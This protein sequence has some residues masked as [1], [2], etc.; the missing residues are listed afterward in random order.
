[1]MRACLEALTEELRRLKAG[2][3][4]EVS[5]SEESLAVLRRVVQARAPER[6][7]VRTEG[8]E[9]TAAKAGDSRKAPSVR[10][11][12]EPVKPEPGFPPPPV[13]A[14][15]EGDKAMQWAWLKQR[16]LN[17]EVCRAQVRP[18]KQLVLGEGDLDAAIL[19]VGEP[20]GAEEEAIGESFVGSAGQLLTKMIGAMGLKR[21]AVYISNIMNW[22]PRVP[23]PEGVEQVGERTPTAEELAYCLPH[24]RA[25]LAI[26]KP[27]VVVALGV[28][29]ARG[30]LG[31]EA[32]KAL[33][34][35]RGEWKEFE[36]TPVMVTYHPSYF[37]RNNSNQSKRLI[38]EDL[39]KVMER[40]DI[41]ISDRQRGFFCSAERK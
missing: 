3:V 29:A 4:K 21:E 30:L 19:F 39:L 10:V 1:M 7:A 26:V 13:V 35:V 40:V 2:G 22:R 14:L 41:P 33:P 15:P 8:A 36:G 24:L 27:K 25:Q 6:V 32:F 28:T 23:T 18:G 31:G 38:W 5:V 9:G 37:L 34:D 16:V 12:E 17:D 20:P 11:V